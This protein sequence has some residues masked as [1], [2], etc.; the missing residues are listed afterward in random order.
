MVLDQF[1]ILFDD[2]NPEGI[3]SA[4]QTVTGRLHLSIS[5]KPETLKGISIKY[6]NNI[7]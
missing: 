5:D 2:D 4:G 1:C 7:L 3:F 6:N